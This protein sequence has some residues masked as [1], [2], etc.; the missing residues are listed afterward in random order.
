MPHVWVH[1][2]EDDQHSRPVGFRPASERSVPIPLQQLC[3]EFYAPPAGT[4]QCWLGKVPH[5]P[6]NGP[7]FVGSAI[8]SAHNLDEAPIVA[9]RTSVAM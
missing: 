6:E 7:V 3:F 2:R 1:A 9:W 4:T 8:V 5:V